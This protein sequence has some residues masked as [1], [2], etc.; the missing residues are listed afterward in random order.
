MTGAV[1]AVQ[2][3]R[4]DR[5]RPSTIRLTGAA[6]PGSLHRWTTSGP[7]Q[8][9][10]VRS[11]DLE[12]RYMDDA[13]VHALARLAAD[14]VHAPD[15]MPFT[16]PWTRGTPTEVA[17]SVL[18]YQWGARASASPE[19]WNLELAVVRDGEVLGTQ[20]LT[21]QRLPGHA[22][23]GDRVVARSAPPRP[24][25]R[26]AHAADDPAPALRGV[27]RPARDDQ[28]VRRQRRLER[29]HPSDRLR[30]ERRRRAG[31]RGH[32]RRRAVGTCWTARRGTAGRPSCAPRSTSS[33]SRPPASSSASD[34]RRRRR[35]SVP[36][37]TVAAP[38]PTRE[39]RCRSPL[40]RPSR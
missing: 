29:R 36:A 2:P 8:R 32:S 28:R 14:G 3:R 11:G 31:P 27:R 37:P 30:R 1:T 22:H 33:G 19:K 16:V 25:H 6:P 12:L 4:E 9:L 38:P 26:H 15:A 21:A 5:Q 23:R 7:S 35:L 39:R 10:R 40:T 17:R 20:S 13:D 24:G 34:A 18:A